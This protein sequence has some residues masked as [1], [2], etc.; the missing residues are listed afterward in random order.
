M[1]VM[2]QKLMLNISNPKLSVNDRLLKALEA[3]SVQESGPTQKNN[4]AN[5]SLYFPRVSHLV[6]RNVQTFHF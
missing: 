5:W 4:L 3:K 2:F 1:F 6:I